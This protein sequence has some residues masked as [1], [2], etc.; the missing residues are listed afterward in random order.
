MNQPISTSKKYTALI[1]EI[2]SGKIK[3]PKFQREFVWSIDKTAGLLDSILKGY[4]IG[5]FILWET[6]ERLS[7][8][9]NIGNFELPEAKDG[10]EVHY[11]L[12]G[13]QR[14]TS[15]FAAYRGQSIVKYGETKE[16]N[17]K[18]I[19]VDLEADIDDRDSILVTH[20]KPEG[21]HVSLHE[22]LQYNDK[23]DYFSENFS[24]EFFKKITKYYTIFNGY[25]F[26]A[27]LL[28]KQDIESAI[29][30]FTRINVGGKTLTLFEIMSAKTYDEKQ[31][32]DM[33]ASYYALIERLK[34]IEYNTISSTIL[35]HSTSLILNE[36]KECN[37]KALLN[38]NKQEIIDI[39][40]DVINALCHSIDFIKQTF[41]IPVSTILP[42]DSLL[43]PFTYF[44]YFNKGNPTNIQ[45]KYLEEFFWRVSLSERYSSSS[46][47]SLSQDVKQR[48]DKILKEER[49]SYEDY[50][51]L[52]KSAED[53]I[54]INFRSGSSICKAIIC[55]LAYQQPKNFDNNSL[56]NLSNAY[57]IRANSKN[58]HHFF[59]KAFLKKEGIRNENS[60]VNITLI[61]DRINKYEIGAKA[62]S[63]YIEDYM[64]SN[65]KLEETLK[66]HLINDIRKFGI[67]N[68]DYDC[69]LSERSKEIYKLLLKR[70][71]LKNEYYESKSPMKELISKG[72]GQELEFKSSLRYCTNQN[73]KNDKLQYSSIKTIAGFLNANGGKLLIGVDDNHNILGLQNDYA[74]FKKQDADGFELYL[75]QAIKK[76]L[77]DSFPKHVKISFE[78]V[79]DKEICV[80]DVPTKFT[81]SVFFNREG[82]E[83]F[84]VREGNAT[85]SKNR[86]E[87]SEYEKLHWG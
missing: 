87:Q 56:V 66:T 2:E 13:Q 5:T 82:K 43:V 73:L 76:H 75:R 86:K 34:K 1:E 77:G 18:N 51:L 49:P 54:D 15:L 70:I 69:F 68:D 46:E 81:S 36:N 62:P 58:Y 11:V 37:K 8:I 78:N 55:L 41:R 64:D 83:D 24:I 20:E 7:D 44:F 9:K 4:P 10:A 59:P 80:V 23:I 14:I 40:N 30:V 48:I 27:I 67:L 72:E 26:S 33:Q 79:D 35:L 25:E 74:T 45:S 53:L 50:N 28:K 19:Y 39:W 61:G 16:T 6:S 29:E 12:D 17:Y 21:V 84:Y 60:I 32:F 22:I 63:N 85:V 3:V 57:L 47:T 38:L 42:Y 71:E 31:G 52:V 65:E